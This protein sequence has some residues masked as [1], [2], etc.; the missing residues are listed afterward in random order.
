LNDDILC[1]Y[2]R[3]RKK[4]KPARLFR[5]RHDH[6]ISFRVGEYYRPQEFKGNVSELTRRTTA[7]TPA[8]A[9]RANND[10]SGIYAPARKR[11]QTG[12]SQPVCPWCFQPRSL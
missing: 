5:R 11:S 8:R 4:Q 12:A 1:L 10:D 9:A 7:G 6:F 3:Q 2:A